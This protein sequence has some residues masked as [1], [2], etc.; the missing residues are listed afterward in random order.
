MDI[1]LLINAVK[2]TLITY[3]IFKIR[4]IKQ[5]RPD[6]AL[7]KIIHGENICDIYHRFIILIAVLVTSLQV[8]YFTFLTF[9]NY[10]GR[11][12]NILYQLFLKIVFVNNITPV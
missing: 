7:T 4:I 11:K 2:L 6:E 5:T 1:L 9:R 10:H 12:C 8:Y 3:I